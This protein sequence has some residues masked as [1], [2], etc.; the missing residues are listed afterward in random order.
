MNRL[1]ALEARHL[2]LEERLKTELRHP[3]RDDAKIA[4]LKHEKLIIKDQMARLKI[5]EAA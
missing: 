5:R 2:R 1:K 4:R 3:A